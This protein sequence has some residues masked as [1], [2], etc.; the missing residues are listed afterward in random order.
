L[1]KNSLSHVILSAAL[2][3]V[4]RGGAKDLL[5]SFFGKTQQMLCCAQHD[6]S[7]FQQ[8]VGVIFAKGPSRQSGKRA[9]NS[10]LSSVVF[11]RVDVLS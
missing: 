3:C 9:R 2:F 11:V 5:Y 10:R 1:L 8:P 7:V 4:E 6:D